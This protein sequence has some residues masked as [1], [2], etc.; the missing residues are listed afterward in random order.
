MA[1]YWESPWERF[2]PTPEDLDKLRFISDYANETSEQLEKGY[3]AL[4]GNDYKKDPV[5]DLLTPGDYIE[6]FSFRIIQKSGPRTR[7]I[8]EYDVCEGGYTVIVREEYGAGQSTIY[9]RKYTNQRCLPVQMVSDSS[10]SEKPTQ[11][12]K[13]KS[14]F[15]HCL[16]PDSNC[17][18]LEREV[19]KTPDDTWS[20]PTRSN[21]DDPDSFDGDRA[22][23]R[24]GAGKVLPPELGGYIGPMNPTIRSMVER[25][26]KQQGQAKTSLMPSGGPAPI[27]P[28]E[29]ERPLGVGSG[30]V[31]PPSGY[32]VDPRR[33]RTTGTEGFTNGYSGQVVGLAKKV[34]QDAFMGDEIMPSNEGVAPRDPNPWE[35]GQRGSVKNTPK[36]NPLTNYIQTTND[37]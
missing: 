5:L 24:Y 6:D 21:H 28:D 22:N 18:D 13:D 33:I 20:V 36:K 23:Q 12:P 32:P 27:D 2:N 15:S 4:F 7:G 35:L 19:A 10:G 11:S 26:V 31:A 30:V 14:P 3:Q 34:F 37:S 17:S 9:T 8:R 1:N 29:P 25:I 16:D